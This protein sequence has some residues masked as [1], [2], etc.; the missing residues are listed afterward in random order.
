VRRP[1]RF[2]DGVALVESSG[3]GVFVEVGPAA[4]LTAAVEQ[5]LATEQALA[6]AAMAKDRSEVTSLVTALGRLF[7]AG[8]DVD[9]GPLFDG[10]GARR[11]ELPTYAFQR[12]RFWLGGAADTPVDHSAA[13]TFAEQLKGLAPDEQHRQLVELV[14]LN[15]AIV[16]GHSS[17]H[18]V[19]ADRA[20]QD[21]GFDSMAGVE[22]RN[23]LQSDTGLALSRTLIF[24]YPT[25]AALADH[26]AE[27]LS[28]GQHKESGDDKIRSLLLRIPIQELRRTGLL[29]RLLALSGSES[30]LPKTT[31][32]D[33]VIDSLGADALIAMALNSA[34]D[35]DI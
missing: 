26:L 34:E 11:V 22:L 19:D 5:S 13:D 17:S 28:G 27:Q 30:P 12:R 21:L 23:R 18:D 4:G 7:T 10:M 20:F 15:A 32:S 1:V 35:D 25:P 8:A 24:D 2:A 31:V 33:D 3:A 6:V 9:W 29:D 16:L 14:C